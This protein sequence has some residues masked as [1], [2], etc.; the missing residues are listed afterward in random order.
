MVILVEPGNPLVTTDEMLQPLMQRIAKAFPNDEVR[1]VKRERHG[2]SVTWWEV[3]IIYVAAA[4]TEALREATKDQIKKLGSLV[5]RAARQKFR[6]GSERPQ[7]IAIYGPDGEVV[8]SVLVKNVKDKV[9]DR[10]EE[11]RKRGQRRPPPEDK[12][13]WRPD[14]G[15]ESSG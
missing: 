14:E 7:Y 2:Y 3:V 13:I 4:A 15:S 11:D 12:K 5:V 10:T 1:I 6:K 9:E 8:R